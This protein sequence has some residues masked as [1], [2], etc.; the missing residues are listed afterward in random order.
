MTARFSLPEFRREALR[1]VATPARVERVWSRLEGDLRGRRSGAVRGGL[2]VWAVALPLAGAA[3][4]GGGA[5]VGARLA[6]DPTPSVMLA[7]EPTGAADRA[8]VPLPIASPSADEDR[9][10]AR[11]PR[12]KRKSPRPRAVDAPPRVEPAGLAAPELVP[13]AAPDVAAAEWHELW[14][15]DE[16]QRAREAIERQGGFDAVLEGTSA[17]EAMAMVD[18]ARFS[19][20][21]A[22]AIA[23]L[24]RIV[25]RFPGD[26]NAPL[27]ALTLG[28]LLDRAGDAKGAA[29]AFSAYR[30]LSP[31]GDFAED[32]LA[33]QIEA[34][35]G[36]GDVQRARELMAQYE[37]QYPA[38][39]RLETLR[40]EVAAAPVPPEPPGEPTRADGPRGVEAAAAPGRSDGA[41]SA[42][43]PADSP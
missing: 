18:I 23:A 30:A 11:A 29:A 6:T 12:G 21:N 14:R 26:P 37:K 7:H 25:D 38:G 41:A 3:L 13:P 20:E 4:F 28:N 9:T 27:A 15:V 36:E 1:D 34:A 24:R 19:H 8:T 32:A 31:D 33:R 17:D 10:D 22:L 42:P 2:P 39:S 16:Y 40:A 35:L 43:A 5:Y